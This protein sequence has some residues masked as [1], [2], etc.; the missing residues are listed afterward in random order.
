MPPNSRLREPAPES[1]AGTSPTLL[2][3]RPSRCHWPDCST[4]SESPSA[5]GMQSCGRS[6]SADS[7]AESSSPRTTCCRNGSYGIRLRSIQ[8]PSRVLPAT[9]AG[10]RACTLDGTR[11]PMPCY[12]SRTS[13]ASA[14][15]RRVS[16][17]LHT[18]RL[19][20]LAPSDNS[21]ARRFPPPLNATHAYAAERIAAPAILISHAPDVRHAFAS[22]FDAPCAVVSRAPPDLT[23]GSDQCAPS[24]EPASA[25]P[26]RSPFFEEGLRWRSPAAPLFGAR[27]AFA[28]ILESSLRSHTLGGVLRIVPLSSSCPSRNLFISGAV[29]VGQIRC[30]KWAKSDARTQLLAVKPKLSLVYMGGVVP[31]ERGDVVPTVADLVD[32]KSTRL[33]SSHL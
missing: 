28:P 29:Q 19:A 9:L 31:N 26:D 32:R 4:H 33:N 11:R 6:R 16:R 24:P 15:P 12:A 5:S 22:R 14:L 25:C 17:L 8:R 1:C 13:T 20:L 21:G 18:N 30:A 3:P 2:P 7:L 10:W 23:P 27:H